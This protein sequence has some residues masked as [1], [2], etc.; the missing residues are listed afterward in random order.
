MKTTQ[1]KNKIFLKFLQYSK[2]IEIFKLLIMVPLVLSG[3][4]NNSCVN[5]PTTSTNM[6]T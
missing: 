5:S 2:E 4:Y 3:I 1:N 6:M